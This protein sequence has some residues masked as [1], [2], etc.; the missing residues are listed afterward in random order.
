[1]DKK[2]DLALF[3]GG[4]N[5]IKIENEDELEEMEELFESYNYDSNRGSDIGELKFPVYTTVDEEGDVYTNNKDCFDLNN[6]EIFSL[7]EVFQV[8]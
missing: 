6:K 2:F 7:D 8:L 4:I 5:F 1:M 3:I